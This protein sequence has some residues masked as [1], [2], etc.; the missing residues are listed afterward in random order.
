MKRAE[1]IEKSGGPSTGSDIGSDIGEGIG[2]GEVADRGKHITELPGPE[3]SG[4][5]APPLESMLHAFW[6]AGAGLE[7]AA[8]SAAPEAAP[9]P[10]ALLRQLGL[11][12]LDVRGT[13]ATTLLSPAYRVLT[14]A[15]ARRAL[16]L[17]SDDQQG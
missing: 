5:D 9:V 12:G 17:G 7:E 2:R 13:E 3:A 10:D 6:Q 11:L 16:G 1:R 8:A 15:A 4:A 14:T